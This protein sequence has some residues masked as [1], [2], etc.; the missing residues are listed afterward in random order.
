LLE[1]KSKRIGIVGLLQESN[2]F[3]EGK[4][5]LD[6]FKED[7]F[8]MGED[9]RRNMVDAPHEVG[10]FFEGLATAG[11]EA[12]PIF[13]ARAIPYGVIES[14]AFE[15]LVEQLL[16]ELE[17][18]DLL[19]AILAAPHGAT[20]AEN[21]PDADGYWLGK[22]RK[23]VGPDLPI[24]ATVDPHANLSQAM[25]E[26]TH[27]II[28]YETNP[29][30]DQ[31]AT[32]RRA[33]DLLTK[34]L[35][36]EIHPVQVAAF[37][38]MA[39]NIQS[40][41]TST[42]PLSDFYESAKELNENHGT[43]SHSIIL[44][45]PY[46]DVPEM[47]SAILVVTDNNSD[48]ATEIAGKLGDALWEARHTFE[49]NFVTPRDAIETAHASGKFPAVLLDMGDNIGGGS[50]ADSTV[51]LEELHNSCASNSF[52]C[53]CDPESTTAAIQAGPQAELELTVGAKNDR[54]H[55][56]PFTARFRVLSIHDGKFTEPEAR[57]GGFTQFD[58][59]PTAIIETLDTDITVMLTTR[60]MP[61]FSLAQL[62]SCGLDPNK[63]SI[64]VAKGVI[65]PLAAYCPIAKSFIH[66]DTPGVTRADMKKLSYSHRRKPMFPFEN[67][68]PR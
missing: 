26:A 39:I 13:L 2:T 20:V 41:E 43:L 52:A 22:V 48:L 23:V 34:I 37:P 61:P 40:Q 38:P 57:H 44:G 7:L 29:H 36:D 3:I 8:L 17:R 12:V 66:V 50:L 68:T 21:H 58:Q 51:L 35:R 49:P 53:I 47:G 16:V 60:R 27:A 10:G 4:T 25:I 33:A 64:I 56:T 54:L 6:H 59:G 62:T 46:A 30:L 28:S 19:D 15:Y 67:T 31:R 5:T 42:T 63:F 18:A 9:I 14:S 24:V 1:V 55:G 32:G 11:Y 45:F 65:A